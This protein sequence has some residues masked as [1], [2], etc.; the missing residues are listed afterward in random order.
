MINGKDIHR[1]TTK[2]LANMIAYIPQYHS[3]V[4]AHTVLD[5]VLMGRAAHFSACE[6]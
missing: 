1:Y 4:F 5:V 2:E 3:P 6:R